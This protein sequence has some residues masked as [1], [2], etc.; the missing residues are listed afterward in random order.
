MTGR[1]AIFE[2]ISPDHRK[3]NKMDDNV[4]VL[5]TNKRDRRTME[6]IQKDLMTETEDEKRRRFE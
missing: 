1:D 6:Q 4:T 3:Q 5:N 2:I